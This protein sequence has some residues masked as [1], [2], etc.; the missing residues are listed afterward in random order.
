M[1]HLTQHHNDFQKYKEE[2]VE[3]MMDIKVQLENTMKQEEK[4][5]T[6]KSEVIASQMQ[7]F[8]QSI[9]KK[10]LQSELD[11]VK[12]RVEKL[13]ANDKTNRD[14]ADTAATSTSIELP[15]P[16]QQ[17]QH[18]GG[19]RDG[20]NREGGNRDG[21]NHDSGNRDDGNRDG[22]N[23]DDGNRDGRNRRTMLTGDVVIMMDSNVNLLELEK[24]W[25]S[26][27]K[28]KTGKS[29]QLLSRIRKHDFSN[30]KTVIIGVG[31]NDTD[32]DTAEDIFRNLVEGGNELTSEYKN[33]KV[34]IA[35]TTSEI[36]NK[37][38]YK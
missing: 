9:Q 8:E 13:L 2:A 6:S 37:Q 1:Q 34:C 36:H 33:I 4:A 28:I 17:Q 22:R 10:A 38:C 20:G 27:Q 30:V 21:G 3:K 24:V 23:R 35:H 16:P 26:T 14:T 18:D 15:P 31:T 19:N 12:S 32:E 29:N 5:R 11:K 7:Q 25:E